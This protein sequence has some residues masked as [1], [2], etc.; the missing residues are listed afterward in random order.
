MVAF[1]FA[2]TLKNIQI[3]AAFI[4]KKILTG[5]SQNFKFDDFTWGP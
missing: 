1:V 3:E 2:F 5:I 4:N